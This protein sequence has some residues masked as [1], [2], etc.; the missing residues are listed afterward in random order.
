MGSKIKTKI[1]IFLSAVLF[2]FC[3]VLGVSLTNKTAKAEEAPTVTLTIEKNNLSYA[4]SIYMLYAVSHEGFDR[5]QHQIKMLF[6]EEAQDEYVV[7]TEAYEV[8]AD[9]YAT[10]NK[11]DCLIFYSAGIAA[12]EMTDN[13]YSRA[14]VEIDGVTYYS[15]VQKYSV[16]EYVYT[17]REAGNLSAAKENLFTAMLDYGAAAQVVLNYKTDRLANATYHK[18][19]VEN[20]TLADGTTMGRFLAGESVTLTASASLDGEEFICWMGELGEIVSEEINTT[21][22]VTGS[23]TYTAVYGEKWTEGLQF[24]LLS[25]D[26]YSVTG[27]TGT[28]TEVVIPSKYRGK[29]VSSIGDSAF[30]DCESLT[31]V[32]IPN[33]VTSIGDNAF[34][35]CKNLTSITIPD[36]VKGIGNAAFSDCENLTEIVIPNSVTSIGN[37]AFYECVGLRSITIP[38]SVTSIGENAFHQCHGLIS[39]ELGNGVTS[40]GNQAFYDCESLTSIVFGD[41]LTTIGVEAFYECTSL[42]EIVI[43]NGVMSIGNS[44]FS[45]CSGLTNVVLPDSVTSI[46]GYAFYGCSSLT[47]I[48]V[49]NGNTAYKDIDGDLYTKDGATLIQ[50]TIGKTDVS[51]VIPDSVTSIDPS[52]FS[53]CSS[54]TEIVIPN[55]VTTIGDFAFAGC[56]GVT[57]YCEAE[58]QPSGWDR[59]WNY[60]E[61]PV[62]YYSEEEPAV[63]VD[64]TAYDGNFWRYVD[65]EINVWDEEEFSQ[66]PP[67]EEPEQEPVIV[68]KTIYWTAGAQVGTQYVD[69]SYVVS[70]D[71]TISSHSKGCWFTTQLRIYDSDSN[72][73]YVI[74]QYSGVVSSLAFNMGYKVTNVEV[75][76]STDGANWVQV[77]TVATTTTSY[78][79]YSLDVDETKGYTYIKLDPAGAQIRITKIDAVILCG[80]DG[81]GNGSGSVTPPAEEEPVT[82]PAVEASGDLKIYFP[83]LQTTNSGDCALIKVGDVEVLIDAGPKRDAAAV[84][85]PY[86][87]QYCTDGILEYV[88][89]THAHE[90]HIAAFVGTSGSDGIFSKFV[91]KTIIDFPLANS[92]SQI[93]SDYKTYRDAE[94]TAGAKHYTALECWNNANGAKRSY[95][96]GG[97]ITLNILYQKYYETSSSSENNHSVALTIS[98]GDKHFLFTGD[99]E[100]DGEAS[101]VASN[102][103]PRCELFKAAHHGSKTSN[104]ATLLSAIQPKIVV[105]PACVGSSQYTEL[106]DSQYPMQVVVERIAPYTDKVYAP[107]VATGKST[108]EYLNG[109]L[110]IVC[111]GKTTTVTGS[112]NNLKLKETDWF[113]ANR[114]M[115]S[116]WS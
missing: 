44:A 94:V 69:E 63:N 82:P 33:G 49:S 109:N 36:S 66:R 7:G 112:N 19:S 56:S 79:N 103:L 61:R 64:G 41:G 111:D 97:D 85:V 81:T 55:S 101:L 13:V 72:N 108:W 74:F 23:E 40:I 5:N 52:A 39:V 96:L 65:G 75:Y 98:Y 100:S 106:I 47:S 116:A 17:A 14:Y 102:N 28:A 113:K 18:I 71:L 45:W 48:V 31:S 16:L 29:A 54:L 58:S 76:G 92:T 20:G 22:A 57:I 87:Q 80:G 10:V 77:G 114:T 67:V 37:E 1:L 27:Y 30:S 4:D 35:L 93:Y 46:G 34:C 95:S 6:W 105:V 2:A 24:T 21:V 73:G 91:C 70:E 89:A 88:I 25:G 83:S 59:D 42:T 32:E 68:E 12:K 15:D 86:I 9:S 53:N 99:L 11:K 104:S 3:G 38:D 115:P 26:T 107:T 84:L 90:D 60:S 43:P 50:Y 78:A 8:T 51:F 110:T 62:Y